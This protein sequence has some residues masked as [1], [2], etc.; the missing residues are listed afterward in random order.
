M[1]IIEGLAGAAVSGA[2]KGV[3]HAVTG[4]CLRQHAGNSRKK[5]EKAADEG[6]QRDR[7]A[8]GVSSWG[9]NQKPE[10]A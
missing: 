1:P 10:F 3:A 6:W 9:D 8:G 4:E 7:E 2:A 5:I